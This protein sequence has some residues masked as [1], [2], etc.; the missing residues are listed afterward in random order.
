MAATLLWR[1]WSCCDYCCAVAVAMAV[2][3]LLWSCWSSSCC[4]VGAVVLWLW[5]SCFFIKRDK[6]LFWLLAIAPLMSVILSTI[7]V[8]LT[9]ADKYGVKI[10]KH[11]NGGLNPILVHQLQF[12][13]PYASEVTKIGLIV[14][15]VALME[16]IAVGL[17]FASIKGYHLDGNKEM[18][19][20]GFMNIVGSLTSC[21]AATDKKCNRVSCFNYCCRFRCLNTYIGHPHRC[22]KSKWICY[23]C[24][25]SCNCYR[26]CCR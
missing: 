22:D 14:A 24:S 12:N 25:C 23:N 6:K 18:L 26:N 4:S 17:S 13:N 19:A 8:F 15:V 21:Y 1:C 7:I 2:A 3:V 20:M 9:R 16:A 5:L 11:I 10:V